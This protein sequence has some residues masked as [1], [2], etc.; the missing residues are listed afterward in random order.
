M[1]VKVKICGLTRSEDVRI[2][3]SAGADFCGVV[4]EVPG[5]KRSRT[6]E[7]ARSLF[8]KAEAATVAV[9][10]SKSLS[11]L[12]ELVR[13]LSPSV[14]QLHGDEKPELVSDLK[15]KVSCQVWKALP[16]PPTGQKTFVQVLL[17]QVQDFIKAGCDAFVLDT[18]TVRGFGGTGVL[19]SWE[20]AAELV[21]FS[22]TPCFLAGGLTPEN[23]S[24]AIAVVKPYGVDVSSGVEISPGIKDPEKVKLF[25][26]NAKNS[27]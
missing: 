20:L 6:K 27:S 17:K 10:R 26:R 21:R 7:Q 1:S 8:E 19:V 25:C 24:E 14:L 11:E 23:V 3:C 16:L 12:I 5:S 13:F 22:N 2:A 9:T 4:V 15:R 18:A